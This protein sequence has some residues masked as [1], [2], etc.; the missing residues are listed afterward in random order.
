MNVQAAIGRTGL[1]RKVRFHPR[2]I[3]LAI[4]T[5][6]GIWGCGDSALPR[7]STSAPTP[8]PSIS[9]TVIPNSITLSSG[10]TQSFTATVAGT[11]NSAVT[12][13]VQE[14]AGG[15]IDS[16]G[17]L[18]RSAKFEGTFKSWRQARQ[19]GCPGHSCRCCS[20][21][22]SERFLLRR[23]RCLLMGRRP[24]RQLSQGS[25]IPV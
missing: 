21:A 24:S 20:N 7:S 25:P 19:S 4:A 18:Y 9:V 8:S 3:A 12:W 13:S 11:T 2:A 22:A 14:S 1:L 5:V 6:L 17:L 15:T 16:T 10:T 23:S